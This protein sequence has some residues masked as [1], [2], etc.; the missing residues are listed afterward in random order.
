[1]RKVTTINLNGRAYQL[2]EQ[3]YTKLQI[4][5]H[6]AETTLA[7]DPDKSEVLADIE[8]AIAD[9]CERL[10]QNGKNVITTGQLDDIL[11]QMGE[12]ESDETETR[13]TPASE[14]SGPKRL[15]VVREGAIF[16]GVCRGIGAYFAIDPTFVRLAFILLTIFTGGFWIV[17]YILLGLF[18]PTAKTDSELAEAYGKPLTAQAILERAKERAPS[19][20]T[21][22]HILQVAVG[23]VGQM[24]RLGVRLLGVAILVGFGALTAAWVWVIW[25]LVFGRLHLYGQLQPLNGWREWVAVTAAYL[26]IALPLLLAGRLC[27]RIATARRQSRMS[28]VSESSLAVLWGLAV[29]TLLAF[30]AAYAQNFRDYTRSHHG[31][32]KIGDTNLCI[33]P[34]DGCQPNGPDYK[35]IQGPQPVVPPPH[36][37]LQ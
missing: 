35:I 9:K 24:L 6:R 34:D 32:V 20:E 16:M 10:L 26:L 29:I 21:W 27:S 8:Q 22:E 2:E 25:Q 17:V 31:H 30:G 19:V 7:K 13:S 1:M 11:D 4:Y 33:V 3:A 28:T 12:V 23:F 5:L 37:I 36:S 18:L 15:F 14:R